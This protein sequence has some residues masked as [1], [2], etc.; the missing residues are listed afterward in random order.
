MFGDNGFASINYS[1][2][3]PGVYFRSTDKRLWRRFL[4][5]AMESGCCQLQRSDGYT[6]NN[7]NYNFRS[8]TCWQLN[9]SDFTSAQGQVVALRQLVFPIVAAV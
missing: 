5:M 8:Y 7:H 1:F 4:C 9:P 2:P 6:D 3:S